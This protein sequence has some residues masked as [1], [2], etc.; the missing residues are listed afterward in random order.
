MRLPH[1]RIGKTSRFEYDDSNESLE[2]NSKRCDTATSSD[3]HGSNSMWIFDL[4]GVFCMRDG[5]SGTT[6]RSGPSF[7]ESGLPSRRSASRT[8]LSVNSESS[9]GSVNKT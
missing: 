8:T 3:E 1:L 7:S 2:R 4:F 9:S 5:S 6:I